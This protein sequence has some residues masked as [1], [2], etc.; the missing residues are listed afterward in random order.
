LTEKISNLAKSGKTAYDDGKYVN[1]KNIFSELLG[2][3]PG[4]ESAGEYIEKCDMKLVKTKKT[5]KKAKPAEK[6]AVIIKDT[7]NIEEHYQQGLI[8]YAGGQLELAVKEFEHTLR[9]DP[10]HKRAKQAL[11]KVKS[12][13]NFSIDDAHPD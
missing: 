12:E 6:P 4:N 8:Y 13:I 2:L 3:D 1:A 10:E 11:E 7:G 9:I 5:A